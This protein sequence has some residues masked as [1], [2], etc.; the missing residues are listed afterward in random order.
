MVEATVVI[1]LYTTN[2]NVREL[3]ALKQVQK[4]LGRH[5]VTIVKPQS[6]NNSEVESIAPHLNYI[7]F[8]DFF[9][10]GI[11]GYNKL[12]LSA[13]FYMAFEKSR[14]ILIYQLD[15]WVF[16]DRLMEWCSKGYDY[17]GAP[18]IRRKVY[19]WPFVRQYMQL[20]SFYK[21][22]LG[23]PDKQMLYNRSGNGGF[24][25]RRVSTHFQAADECI[26]IIGEFTSKRRYH[27]Y[28]EDVFWSVIVNKH[29][30]FKFSYPGYREALEFSFDK[31]PA[32][33]FDLNGKKLPFGC[34]GWSKKEMYPFWKDIINL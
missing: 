24:S 8:P 31:H 27:M 14:Y 12:M 3:G 1:P 6:L 21:K 16:E 18:W 25:L 23:Q 20:K 17:I 32:Y 15:A 22:V 10:K 9:F 34:H 26:G 29:C 33:C 19:D 28:N 13:E 7:S 5:P 4:V 2:L 30:D 11:E